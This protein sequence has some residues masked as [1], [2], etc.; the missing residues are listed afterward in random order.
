MNKL[1]ILI[2]LCLGFLKSCL[3]QCNCK[4]N[5]DPVYYYYDEDTLRLSKHNIMSATQKWEIVCLKCKYT[6][7]QILNTINI[8]FRVKYG[9]QEGKFIVQAFLVDNNYKVIQKIK[10]KKRRNNMII[11]KT[12]RKNEKIAI[13][14]DGGIVYFLSKDDF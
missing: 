4:I 3:S 14:L 2:I 9:N 10:L 1:L 7:S 6:E 8:D 12:F 5:S 13:C 11:N